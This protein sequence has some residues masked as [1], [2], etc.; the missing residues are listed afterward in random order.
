MHFTTNTISLKS[1]IRTLS[2]RLRAL[3]QVLRAPWRVPMAREQRELCL[4]KARAT[5]LC[6]L[7]AFSRG[8]LHLTRPPRGAPADWRSA[9]YHRAIAERLGPSY[10]SALEQSA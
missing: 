5:E 2:Q 9:D 6:A 8:R 4:L 1:D 3:K 7:A 10:S